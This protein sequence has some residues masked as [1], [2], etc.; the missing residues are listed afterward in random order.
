MDIG[1]RKRDQCPFFVAAVHGG[2]VGVLAWAETSGSKK[3]RGV[4]WVYFVLQRPNQFSSHQMDQGKQN[5]VPETEAHERAHPVAISRR[6][7]PP[8]PQKRGNKNQ[9]V[10]RAGAGGSSGRSGYANP[11]AEITGWTTVDDYENFGTKFSAM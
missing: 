10:E 7:L 1:G 4:K 6:S 9:T 5:G 11:E 8:S 3:R 2:G